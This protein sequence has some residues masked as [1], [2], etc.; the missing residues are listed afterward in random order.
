MF[1]SRWWTTAELGA[2]NEVFY[3]EELVE[4]MQR[5]AGPEASGR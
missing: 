3:P 1:E 4:I 2:T 5:G